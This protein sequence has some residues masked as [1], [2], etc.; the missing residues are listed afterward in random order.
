MRARMSWLD[1]SE[2]YALVEAALGIL[3][4][5]GI[6][7]KGSRALPLLA[8][9]GAQVDHESGVVKLPPD[10]VRAAL[11]LCPRRVVMAGASAD[12]DVILDDG[13]PTSFCSSG[14]GAFILDHETGQRR[15]SLLA[16]VRAATI[17]L[18]EAPVVDLIWTVLTPTDVPIETRELVGYYV[19]LSESRKHVTF[20][21]CP[22]RAET[23]TAMMPVLSGSYEAFAERPRF[24]TLMTVA[25]PLRIDGLL[26]DLHGTVAA[27]GTPVKIYAL[28][29]AGA[30]SPVTIA[31]TLV[32]GLAETLGAVTALQALAPG[33]RP[34]MA[35]A[36]STIDM[37]TAGFSY[38][39]P[40]AM[41]LCTAGVELA[42]FLGL[43][44]STPGL[45]TEGKE[46]GVQTGYEKA[47]KGLATA[48]VEA[49]VMSGGVGMIDTVNTLSLPEIVIDSEIVAMIKRMLAQVD[50]GESAM[51]TEMI[52]RVGI[53]GDYLKEKE[54][55]RR[56]R[57]GEHF[58][59]QISTRLGYEAWLADGR[60]ERRRAIELMTR[61]LALRD[62][63]GPVLDDDR[64]AELARL[65]GVTADQ[66]RVLGHAS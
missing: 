29:M 36:G 7:M 9:Q 21:D 39:S 52:A 65:C 15:P 53:G 4:R 1:E 23:L 24:S 35:L 32:Q 34:I 27:Y 42:H 13:Q 57:A 44:A 2:K 19:A 11:A 55:S 3:E 58:L 50:L 25:S 12:D 8:A 18:D 31:G 64:R 14:C 47:L 5:V 61:T 63:L 6:E 28:P 46:I 59:A 20:V 30:T 45:S 56:L 54:T 41:Q 51:L 16:D 37:R 43:P 33:G 66:A 62:E 22:S 60:N 49:D 26:L 17:L 10:L 48:A 40:E 38:S